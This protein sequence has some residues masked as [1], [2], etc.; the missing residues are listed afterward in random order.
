MYRNYKKYRLCNFKLYNQGTYENDHNLDN[1][2]KSNTFMVFF[3]S[4]CKHKVISSF[5]EHFH[6]FEICCRVKTN[7]AIYVLLSVLYTAGIGKM[8][9][10]TFSHILKTRVKCWKKTNYLLAHRRRP[11]LSYFRI[12]DEVVSVQLPS[13]E[14]WPCDLNILAAH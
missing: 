2:E 9:F 6:L 14:L 13:L 1:G 4:F 12:I 11:G 7:I 8:F 3:I 5:G 10:E